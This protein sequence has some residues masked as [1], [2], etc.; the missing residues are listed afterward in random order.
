MSGDDLN[1]SQI[2]SAVRKREYKHLL[3]IGGH[4]AENVDSNSVV[5]NLSAL[6]NLLI[7]SNALVEQG[8]LTDRVGQSAE[9]VLDAQVKLQFI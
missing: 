4:A 8:N 6:K 1:S 2:Q 3:E 7:K 5:D 9:V